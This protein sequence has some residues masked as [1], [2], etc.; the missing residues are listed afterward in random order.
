MHTA[1]AE[2][3][4]NRAMLDVDALALLNLFQM[5]GLSVAALGAFPGA[6]NGRGLPVVFG[7]EHFTQNRRAVALSAINDRIPVVSLNDMHATPPRP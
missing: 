7:I 4:P 6:A 5:N 1:A 3:E 2:T